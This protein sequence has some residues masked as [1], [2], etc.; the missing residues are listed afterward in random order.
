MGQPAMEVWPNGT[1]YCEMLAAQGC[2]CA[3]CGKTEEGQNLHVDH[4]HKRKKGDEGFVRG[5]LCDNC[6]KGLGHFYDNPAVI[7]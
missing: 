1:K 5:L 7:G 6:N 4:D 3:V 2:G